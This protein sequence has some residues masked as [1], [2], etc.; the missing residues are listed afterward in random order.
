[1]ERPF[2]ASPWNPIRYGYVPQPRPRPP[3]AK[4]RVVSIPVRFVSSEE[5]ERTAK[6]PAAAAAAR[7]AG[8]VDRDVAAVKVQKVVRGFLVRKNVRVVHKVAAEVDEIERKIRA[9]EELIRRDGKERLRVNEMLMAL[10]L[11][12]DSVRGVRDYRK[13]VI[14]RVISLQDAV[15]SIAAAARDE[16]EV[17]GEALDAENGAPAK[18]LES[19]EEVG[20][21]HIDEE[22]VPQE[23]GDG[24]SEVRGGSPKG[25]GTLD[26]SVEEALEAKDE[27]PES[28]DLAE[29]SVLVESKSVEEGNIGDP[30]EE[31]LGNSPEFTAPLGTEDKTEEAVEESKVE[32]KGTI[33]DP[34]KQERTHDQTLSGSKMTG[35]GAEEGSTSSDQMMEVMERVMAENERLK[36]LVTELCE[37]SNQQCR[38]MGGLVE[39]VE[40]LERRMEKRRKKKKKKNTKRRP[41]ENK[42][43]LCS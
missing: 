5:E 14:R 13:K 8:E 22:A 23:C 10:L 30:M 39:T 33:F 6:R 4:S 36:R 25:F 41:A 2:F 7:Q 37:R 24:I 21:H 9:E 11:R 38:L 34:I 12:L 20:E 29:G 3:A 27:A 31:T 32:E 16:K 43:H 15:D 19:P 1:M 18:T 17:G 42:Y 40:D 28:K 35:I 26:D